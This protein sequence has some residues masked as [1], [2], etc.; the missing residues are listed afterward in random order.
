[1]IQWLN[2]RK[3]ISENL[4]GRLVPHRINTMKRLESLLDNRIHSCEIDLQI[5]SDQNGPYF[6]I[7]HDETEV[8]GLHLERFLA[9]IQEH[10]PKKLWLDIKNLCP[11]NI[12]AA[13]LELNHLD[14][15]YNIKAIA[16]IESNLEDSCFKRISAFGYHTS[17]YLPTEKIATLLDRNDL[18]LLREIAN[19]L[20]NQIRNQL[21]SAVS[22]N[23]SL[24]PFVK[25]YLEPVIPDSIVYHTWDSAKIWEWNALGRLKE[26]DYFRDSKVRTILYKCR[27]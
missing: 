25:N 7:G 21:V 26:S 12:D 5:R 17:Y 11:E 10:K 1:M 13:I 18:P 2:F 4:D 3:I 24:Y 15:I 9:T 6:E 8:K 20:N 19:T 23:V 22:F 14:S 27:D 16:I